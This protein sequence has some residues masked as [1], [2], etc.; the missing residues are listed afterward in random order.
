MSSMAMTNGT[1]IAKVVTVPADPG[2]AKIFSDLSFVN[3]VWDGKSQ[4]LWFVI[5]VCCCAESL[6]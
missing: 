1:N 2:V 5:W 3:K 6:R 4:S